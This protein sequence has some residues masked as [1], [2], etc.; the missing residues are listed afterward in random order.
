MARGQSGFGGYRGRATVTDRLRLL[1]VVLLVLVILVVCGLLFGQRYIV[2]T[3]E[4]LRLDLPFMQQE[5][6]PSA[7]DEV[8]NVNVVVQPAVSD[9]DE[10]QDTHLKAAVLPLSAVLEGNALEQV[11][12]LGINTLVLEM[13]NDMGKLAFPTRQPL[14]LTAGAAG[15]EQ[16]LDVRLQELEQSGVHLVARISCF[17]DHALADDQAYAIV[18]NPGRRWY[19]EMGVRWSSPASPAVQ[20]YLIALMEELA[21]MGFD[22]ILLDNWGY[23]DQTD[24]HLEYI[25]VG[26]AY[27]RGELDGVVLTFLEQ[28]QERLSQLDVTLSVMAGQNMFSG[29]ADSGQTPRVLCALHGRIWLQAGVDAA[30]AAHVLAENGM[31]DGLEHLVETVVLLENDREV[32]QFLADGM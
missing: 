15:E 7:S 19:D 18:T 9:E 22:E 32:H 2:Y 21:G 25:K 5:Q 29:G 10:R 4:G 26:T 8:E 28:A 12:Q 23:P 27:P 1:A 24:G 30:G 11:Q 13:K 31:K 6:K 16:G 14:A 20:E 17:R 3:D